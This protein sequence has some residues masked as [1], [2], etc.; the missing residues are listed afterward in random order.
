MSFKLNV[1]ELTMKKI[2]NIG[3]ILFLGI[4]LTQ[5][6]HAQSPKKLTSGNIHEKIQ[7]LQVLGSVLY[8]A[9]H[10][11][12]ENT[13]MIAYLS[14]ELKMNT[15]YLS[16]TR[17]DG[18]QNL[19][20]PEI[21]ELLGVIRTEEL[22][23]ARRVDGGKQMFSRANDFGYSKK[24]DETLKIWEQ[25][26]V[27][28]D[29]V[30]AIRKFQPDVVI[31]RF[32]HDSGR[33]THGHHTSS[34]VLSHKA[35]DLV[36][37]KTK[38]PEQLKYV[39]PWQ[40]QRLF[41]NTSW[42]FYGSRE[43]FAAADKSKMVGVDAGVY[44]P[45]KGKSNNE[46][47]AESRSMHKCQGM[48]STPSR[49]AQ[50][51]YLELLKGDMPKNKEDIFDG[52]N[53]S[54][55]RIKGG[56]AIGLLLE[57]VDR[58]FNYGNPAASLP[59]LTEAYKMISNLPESYYK[60]IK[61]EELKDIIIGSMGLFVEAKANDY[62]ATPGEK[63]ELNMEIINRSSANVELLSVNYLPTELDSTLNLK[64]EGNQTYK[65]SKKLN[66]PNDMPLTGPY[67]LTK[68]A[69][70]GMYSVDNQELRGLPNTPR[71]F[72]VRFNLN[73]EGLP[74]FIEKEI[75]YKKTDPVK[76]EVYRPFEVTI[77]IFAN[78]TEK[79]FVFSDDKPKE[80][81]VLLKS[82]KTDVKG[83]L[84]LFSDKNWKVEPALV[85]FE[86]N[87]KGEEQSFTFKL[88]P[89]QNQEVNFISPLVKIGEKIYTQELVSIEY[90]HIPTQTVVKNSEAKVVKIDL[91]KEGQNVGY[92]M[93]A[94]DEIPIN[95]EQIGYN[96]T[97]LK[98]KDITPSNLGKFDAV[99]LGIR[100]YNT[101]ER[102]RFYQD[103]LFE[104]VEQGGTMIVQYNT[105]H[106]L[107]LPKEKIAPYPIS[108][109]RGRVAVE[110]AEIRILKPDHH[111]MNYP[112]KITSKDFDGWVQERG[113]YFPDEWDENFEAILSSNDSNEPALDGGLLITKYGKGYYVYTGYSWFRELPA[114]VPGAYRIFANMISLGK[115]P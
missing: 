43:K 90:D 25:D 74:L 29:V 75:I 73:I 88:Y 82:G 55:T 98:D 8:V 19:I 78:L 110:E 76:G 14:N 77:P 94:G 103:K 16:L 89:P 109:S 11:D 13:R 87:M 63:V 101:I 83:T 30:W 95:L 97:L 2:L 37:D 56:K 115:R 40:P 35:F 3:L 107:K 20:G 17:G 86:L 108:I 69:S 93:G 61:L 22:L 113:L 50:M 18:G 114:G 49:G 5:N 91:K 66:L 26:E 15:A 96:V 27:V 46:I 59:L 1:K 65:F 24:P 60:N 80:V 36:G 67:W 70:L 99:I 41:M 32:S 102:I 31:N 105:G 12:D 106:R 71:N 100:A 57:Q 79:V 58:N 92:I 7:K 48:G 45:I 112:N 38:F 23:A 62:S 85:N 21:R 81:T 6:I 52:I 4:F 111:V 84:E 47:A 72:K 68:K 42:W 39:K 53:T 10:P 104:Y 34:A 33:R 44:Y 54:W 51:E 28:A 9:A 64:L